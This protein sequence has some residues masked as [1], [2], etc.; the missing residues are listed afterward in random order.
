MQ[1]DGLEV[2]KKLF[3][4][5]VIAAGCKRDQVFVG[6]V[7]VLFHAVS[8]SFRCVF[9]FGVHIFALKERYSKRLTYTKM[10]RI[11]WR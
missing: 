2:L 1:G 11:N 7:S 5:I 6:V 10:M 9:L 8:L 3:V 4:G